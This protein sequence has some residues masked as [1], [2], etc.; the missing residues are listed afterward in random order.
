MILLACHSSPELYRKARFADSLCTSFCAAV[1]LA[2]LQIA[3]TKRMYVLTQARVNAE[4]EQPT[5]SG[6]AIHQNQLWGHDTVS[7]SIPTTAAAAGL[8]AGQAGLGTAPA[9]AA[10]QAKRQPQLAPLPT[11]PGGRAP[12]A[13]IG[14]QALRA[15]STATA[16]TVIWCGPSEAISDLPI[17]MSERVCEHASCTSASAPQAVN[18]GNIA[19]IRALGLF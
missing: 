18:S 19:E 1:C 14:S 12:D 7:V 9:V 16:G 10:L 13:V 2:L 3:L 11:V 15:Q 6:L 4:A 8:A 5:L 17:C